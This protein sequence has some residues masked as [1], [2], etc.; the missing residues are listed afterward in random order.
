MLAPVRVTAPEILPVSIEEAK[1]RLRVDHGD[2]DDVINA[3][4]AAAVEHLDGWTGILGRCLVEQ[5]WRQD[6]E[7]ARQTL[8]LPL[9]PVIDI[10]SVSFTDAAGNG[11]VVDPADYEL[12][13]DAAGRGGVLLRYEAVPRGRPASVQFKAGYLTIP[14]QADPERPAESTVPAPIKTAIMLMVGNWY[15]NS[16]AVNVGNIVNEMPLGVAALLAPYRRPG[17]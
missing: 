1:A 10:V 15:Q 13:V 7:A 6:F 4:L 11:A 12:K 17:V 3:Y 2:D 8:P 16:E 5:E 14:A 9:G